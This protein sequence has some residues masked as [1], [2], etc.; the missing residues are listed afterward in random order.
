MALAAGKYHFIGIGGAGMAPLAGILLERGASVSGSDPERNR[1]CEDLR[2]RGAVI[3]DGHAACQVPDG[4][5]VIYSSAI[6]RDNPELRRA[7]ELG[8]PL[9]RRGEF[10]ARI[11]DGCRRCVAVSGSH[12]KTSVTGM[13][14]WCLARHFPGAGWLAGGDIPGFPR[15]RSGDG[16]IFVTE[17]DE[18]DGTHTLV[19]PF[20]GLVPNV[21]DD[22]DWSVGGAAR[23]EENFR[24]FGAHSSRILALKHPEIRKY[25]GDRAVMIDPC[26]PEF[27]GLP[28]NLRGFQRM[29]GALVTACAGEF[30]LSREEVFRDLAEFPG[31]ERRL[32][33][34][35]T[36]GAARIIE[37]YAHHPAEVA[38][39]M[40]ALREIA[41]DGRLTVVFQPHRYARLEKYFDRLAAELRRADR[42]ILV[43][44]FAAWCESGKVG[45]A[46]LAA[47]VGPRAEY[48]DGEDWG[49]L[50][51]R[52]AAGPAA[53]E[54]GV[55]AVVGAGSVGNLIRELQKP[56]FRR[57]PDGPEQ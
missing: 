44:V 28:E 35:G 9:F 18:S 7:E 42:V 57:V 13:L 1:R 30:G 48:F 19:H 23:L 43:P 38:A 31:V 10:L 55:L 8:L 50:A 36:L 25:F 51:R 20:L 39:S 15:S 54:K 16:D 33:D 14:A 32:T 26:A 6:A 52:L 29:N 11:A 40:T 47:A 24:L 5:T 22:H 4:A 46:E 21:D 41:G 45:S 53:E 12:G 34:R 2:A 17:V 27:S 49:L 37:D 3:Y 56:E